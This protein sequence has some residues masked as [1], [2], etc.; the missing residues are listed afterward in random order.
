M[1]QEHDMQLVVW[2][3]NAFGSSFSHVFCRDGSHPKSIELLPFT[4][5]HND[6]SST[7]WTHRTNGGCSIVPVL[8]TRYVHVCAIPV[9]TSLVLLRRMRENTGMP[10]SCARVARVISTS[11]WYY[12]VTCDFPVTVFKG[13][14]SKIQRL[15]IPIIILITSR[16]TFGYEGQAAF[17]IHL[18]LAQKPLLYLWVCCATR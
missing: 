17:D 5:V 12:I 10:S 16:P 7:T 8:S 13:Q 6:Q 1:D 3:S 14:I 4:E 18:S 11:G 2:Q 15:I 9:S